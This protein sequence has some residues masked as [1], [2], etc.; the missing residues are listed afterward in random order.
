MKSRNDYHKLLLEL[1]DKCKSWLGYDYRV[2]D[3]A[4]NMFEVKLPV[5]TM[6]EDCLTL[7]VTFRQGEGIYISDFNAIHDAF[8][9]SDWGFKQAL[10]TIQYVTKYM[11]VGYYDR[12]NQR[13]IR[14]TTNQESFSNDLRKYVATLV[15]LCSILHF[16]KATLKTLG[17]H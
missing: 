2:I 11:G 3:M 14:L 15:A 13:E 9:Y 6:H 17:I 10:K 1:L 8:R 12:D 7:Y 4:N 5:L 16:S